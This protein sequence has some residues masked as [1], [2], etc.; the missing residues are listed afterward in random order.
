MQYGQSVNINF[1]LINDS[2]LTKTSNLYIT[3]HASSFNHALEISH[4]ISPDDYLNQLNLDS[5]T[6]TVYIYIIH[7]QEHVVI[8]PSDQTN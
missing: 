3:T 5:T 8:K 4:P 2:H 6:N 1:L 7:I